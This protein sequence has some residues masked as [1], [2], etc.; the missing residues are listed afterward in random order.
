MPLCLLHN[1]CWV[2]I[3]GTVYGK[4]QVHDLPQ[5]KMFQMFYEIMANALI[6]KGFQILIYV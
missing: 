6:I 3:I 4:V 1:L 2:P 5:W